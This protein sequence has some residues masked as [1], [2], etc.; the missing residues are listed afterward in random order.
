MLGRFPCTPYPPPIAATTYPTRSTPAHD[1]I[2]VIHALCVLYAI[3]V[4]PLSA[5]GGRTGLAPSLEEFHRGLLPR[6]GGRCAISSKP[7]AAQASLQA[8]GVWREV[9]EVR[10]GGEAEEG[11]EGLCQHAYDGFYPSALPVP[12]SVRTLD[13]LGPR[14]R[15]FSGDMCLRCV[16]VI[17]E[18]RRDF[19]SMEGLAG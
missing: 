18:Y 1:P 19:P 16:C 6:W 17:L 3:R 15:W 13:P 12:H 8:L 9:R 7:C 10:C 4:R 5:R 2:C 11:D 14:V